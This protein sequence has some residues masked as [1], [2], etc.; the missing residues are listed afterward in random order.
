[1]FQSRKEGWFKMRP[2]RRPDYTALS[3]PRFR[4]SFV[5]TGNKYLYPLR[6]PNDPNICLLSQTVRKSVTCRFSWQELKT[7]QN[8]D[9]PWDRA[10]FD[11]LQLETIALEN[12]KLT[13]SETPCIIAQA[14]TWHSLVHQKMERR[15]NLSKLRVISQAFSDFEAREI[16]V[17]LTNEGNET[18][19]TQSRLNFM[20][21]CCR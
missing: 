4:L 20:D 3:V 5:S 13:N 14:S 9:L 6:H 1:M 17:Q 15:L 8:K 7:E 10:G 16:I 19:I 11:R 18:Q 21:V 2:Q 12:Y